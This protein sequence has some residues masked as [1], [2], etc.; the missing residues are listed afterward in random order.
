M[1]KK[2]KK[3]TGYRV[4]IFGAKGILK[5]LIYVLVICCV[6]WVCRTSYSFGYSIF[7]QKAMAEEP[8]Q[9]VTVVIPEGSSVNAIGKI[10]E[11]K[12][13]IESP[14][15]FTVQEYLSTFHGKLMA[16]TYLLNTAMTPDDI[17]E[18]LSG[19]NPEG[20]LSDTTDESSVSEDNA[21]SSEGTGE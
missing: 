16:G 10:L 2:K 4:A 6:I 15:I 18:I 20:R 3:G 14:M 9:A 8:G 12:G 7:K 21:L 13:L 19:E 5:I 11:Q 17:M 1:A